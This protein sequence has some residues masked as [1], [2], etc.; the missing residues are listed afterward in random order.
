MAFKHYDNTNECHKCVLYNMNDNKFYLR[1]SHTII[2]A[3]KEGYKS[4]EISSYDQDYCVDTLLWIIS[5]S[6]HK[7]IVSSS[8]KYN[9]FLFLI[10]ET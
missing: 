3:N 2:W 4:K 7:L 10:T 9:L 8:H 5:L 6:E 1:T